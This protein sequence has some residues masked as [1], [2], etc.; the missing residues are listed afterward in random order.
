MRLMQIPM[1]AW[2]LTSS[3]LRIA[4]LHTLTVADSISAVSEALSSLAELNERP[5]LTHA[6]LPVETAAEFLKAEELVR[7][8]LTGAAWP[9]DALSMGSDRMALIAALSPQ[10]SASSKHAHALMTRVH[11][12]LGDDVSSLPLLGFVKWHASVVANRRATGEEAEANRAASCMIHTPFI[13]TDPNCCALSSW[14]FRPSSQTTLRRCFR[15]SVTV[16]PA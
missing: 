16:L 11:E 2:T 12:A 15:N 4:A 5:A 1:G 6:N 7:L 8:R 14:A 3:R 9:A 10:R 13:T